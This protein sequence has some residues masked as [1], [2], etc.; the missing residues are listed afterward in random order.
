ML[1]KAR[2]VAAA[3]RAA[4]ALVIHAPITF[5]KG[6]PELAPEPYGILA[7]WVAAGVCA[8]HMGEQ[9]FASR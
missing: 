8:A 3:A 2:A 7:K 4:G 1:S 6:Y 5:E 9:V